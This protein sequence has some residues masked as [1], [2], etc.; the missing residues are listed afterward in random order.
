MI[1]KSIQ[2]I[3][4]LLF[5]LPI[6]ALSQSSSVGEKF[7]VQI[8]ITSFTDN[9]VAF[10][11][12]S[13][14]VA[15]TSIY[16]KKITSTTWT[17]LKRNYT[18]LTFSDTTI[19]VGEEYEYKF[20][21]YTGTSP[22]IAYG[23][24]SF[25]AKIPQVTSRGNLLLVVDDRF[26]TSLAAEIKT[27]TKDLIGDGWNPIATYCSKDTSVSYVKSVIDGINANN[28]L[29]GIYLIGHIPVP[30]SGDIYPDGHT[31][32][33]GAWPTD[34]YYAS[35]AS[36][37]TDY[38]VNRTNSSR[39]ANS[40]L[41][42]DGKFDNSEMRGE[43]F[44]PISRVDFYDLPKV[45]ANETAVLSNYLDKASS[46]KHGGIAVLDKGLIDDNLSTF[47]E[48]FSFNGHMNFSSLFGDSVVKSSLL[49]SLQTDTYK[50]S[51]ACSF[52]SDSSL[53]G[54][55]SVTTLKN[56]D[57]QGIFSMVFGSYFGD[58]NTENNFMRSLLADGKMLTTCWAGRPN[59]F[60]HQMG[61][62][63]P[64]GTSAKMSVENS[65]NSSYL[66]TSSYDIYGYYSNGVHMQL[67]GDM[68]LRQNY[69]KSITTLN[70][71][72]N[73]ST[74]S[75]DLAWTAPIGELVTEYKIYKSSD[76]LANFTLLTTL[77]STDSVFSD[78]LITSTGN[79]YY[80]T[81]VTLDT[82]NSGS[83]YNRS[84]GTFATMDT[85]GYANS[86]ALPMELISFD[87]VNENGSAKLQ[88]S[89]ASEINSSHFELEKSTDGI[90][91]DIFNHIQAAGYSTSVINYRAF[92]YNLGTVKTYYRLKLVD[93]DGT[94]E[95]SD[96]RVIDPK[97]NSFAIYPNPS[98]SNKI[99]LKGWLE[100]MGKEELRIT[101]T[102]GVDVPF[103][104]S[105]TEIG[106]IGIEQRPGV[107][108]LNY[109]NEHIKFILL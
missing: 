106:Q 24:I 102:R 63:N 15:S 40:N 10:S 8:K 87:V 28:S 4:V 83:Y 71:T 41:V 26:E 60:F 100:P 61:L 53:S 9:S 93:F 66:S 65:S 11:W 2:L 64:I 70:T 96:V 95:Y 12:T 6:S 105:A 50:W 80:I 43:S 52:G 33:R 75:V 29:D 5:L 48:G 36:D 104:L 108:Y 67:L 73:A 97:T 74:A 17:R 47:S 107:Y 101:D 25:G 32:H 86:S 14:A 78:S 54:V 84:T 77:L 85:T 21:V 94:W 58:W 51:Y 49:S 56:T 35:D 34:L 37:W 82:T 3:W 89:T 16:R 90:T 57:Y 45:A 81:Y 46:Y 92:D 13:N 38:V 30:Y 88:W 39:S 18:P 59:W 76:S 69:K 23:Y 99:N 98:N 91:W 62:N 7:T 55:G 42:G 44:C 27:L 68:T 20:Q 22:S 103:T 109:K 72:Y 79:Y 1:Q 19:V 31:D